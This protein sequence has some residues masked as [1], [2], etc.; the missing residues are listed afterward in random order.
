MALRDYCLNGSFGLKYS[1]VP[2]VIQKQA[3]DFRNIFYDCRPESA[4]SESL[5]LLQRTAMDLIPYLRPQELASV[6]AKLESGSCAR[7]LSS[8][9]KNWITLLKA[10]GGRDAGAMVSG[11]KSILESGKRVQPDALR[12]L[13]ASGM[14]GSLMPGG[15]NLPGLSSPPVAC[16][17]SRRAS[18]PC[19]I[20]YP[21]L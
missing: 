20:Q 16:F 8:E 14:V 10:V 2:P 15:E 9:E 3:A 17:T 1:R 13:V 12:F 21:R 5:G 6:W 18:V 11:A 4:P 19:L 7:L